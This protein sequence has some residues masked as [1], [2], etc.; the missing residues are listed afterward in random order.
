MGFNYAKERTKF[1]RE[2]DKLRREYEAAGMIPATIEEMY[3]YD[4]QFFNSC[5]RYHSHVQQL[6]SDYVSDGSESENSTLHQKFSA[7]SVSF[8]ETDML[9]RYGW[10][11]T[12]D[13]PQM[14]DALK[15]LSPQDLELLT[16]YVIDGYS[17]TELARQYG[18]SQKHIN[19]KLQRI[20]N[21]FAREV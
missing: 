7:L 21:N 12:I 19:K 6:P 3:Q 2:W 4:L 20:K 18:I 9:G 14:V 16:R 15:K 17:Q 11:D 13:A 5:R 10:V 8:D 1:D